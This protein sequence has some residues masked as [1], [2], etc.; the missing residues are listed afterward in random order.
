MD[1]R[2]VADSGPQQRSTR[3]EVTDP[4]PPGRRRHGGRRTQAERSAETREKLLDATIECLVEYGYSGTT[5]PRVAAKAGVTRGAQVHHFRSKADLVAAAVRHLAVRRAEVAVRELGR[6]AGA[7]DMVEQSLD[8]LWRMHQGPMFVATVELWVAA[9]TDPV[10]ARHI[11]DVEP[12]VTR[13][14]ALLGE[15]I[16]GADPKRL[17]DFAFTAMD[18][19]RGILLS[20]YADGDEPRRER[21]WSRVKRQ[22]LVLA[23]AQLR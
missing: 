20:G 10:L 13:N 14:I 3:P 16:A 1:S 22:L 7:G 18:A 21:Q 19:I 5:T 9:R 6:L 15:Q 17:R 2:A 8:L 12:I 23:D 4:R 11:D